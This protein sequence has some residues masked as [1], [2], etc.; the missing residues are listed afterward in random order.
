MTTGSALAG[1]GYAVLG[2][3]GLA[4]TYWLI[5]KIDSF[6]LLAVWVGTATLL[7]AIYGVAMCLINQQNI[8]NNKEIVLGAWL[9]V[10]SLGVIG[11]G[12]NVLCFRKSVF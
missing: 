2:F 7:F 4:F 5:T 3:A 6:Q 11:L 12:I 1:L 9:G 10:V 8:I